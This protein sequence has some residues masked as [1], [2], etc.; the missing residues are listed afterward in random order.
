M[1]LIKFVDLF[2][3]IGAIRLGLEQACQ[4]LG[5]KSECVLTSEIKTSAIQVYQENFQQDKI[6]GDITTISTQQIP[7]FDI[8]L[9]G[10]P[11]QPFSSAGTRQGF[12]DTRGTLFFEIERILKDKSPFGFL[13]ENVEGLVQHDDGRTLTTI[14]NKLEQLGY[15]VKY[16]VL[17]AKDFGV[18]QDRKR[19]YIAGTKTNAISLNFSKN[20]QPRLLDILETGCPT[21]Q[22]NFAKKLLQQYSIE[23]LYGK[24]I[25]DKR[26]GEDNIHSW[27]LEL[28][29]NV[30]LVQRELLNLLLKQRRRKIWSAKK[31]IHWMDGIPLTVDEIATFY[32]HP[33]LAEMLDDLANKGYLKYEHPKDIQEVI[34][35]DGNKVKKREYR[36][37][38][39][40][41][42]NI[43]VG[44][45][46][47]PI[48]KILDPHDIAPTLVATDMQ[49]LAVVD[50]DGLRCLTIREGLRLFGFPENYHI[51]LPINKAFDLLGNTV[52]VPIV[53]EIA[54]RI[55]IQ[56][57]LS[58]PKKEYVL[59]FL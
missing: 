50:G 22:T 29:G 41:G 20:A 25:K 27:D 37:D 58:V 7:D 19:V 55:V 40:K 24:S 23:Q 18:P 59:N 8:L 6:W 46:S 43:V 3:G 26:G 14:V 44:K 12:L 17:N 4:S 15:Q 9:A 32:P 35:K 28:K 2:A 5:F 42:Y 39:P 45:L 56:K 51:N 30:S 36:F 52:V 53:R 16:D 57:M 11:C 48:N 10:F 34:N 31:G 49:K 1:S 38:L 13:L 21:L 47:F 33:K 54:E